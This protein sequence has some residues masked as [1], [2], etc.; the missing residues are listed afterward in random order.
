[1][2]CKRSESFEKHLANVSE[3][4]KAFF[5]GLYGDLLETELDLEY[6]NSLVEG[7]NPRADDTIKF[8]REKKLPKIKGE[9]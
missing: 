6:R 7:T 8:I 9:I 2:I 5:E 3:D 1:M 4:S